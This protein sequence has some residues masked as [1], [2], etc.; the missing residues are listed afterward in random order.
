MKKIRWTLDKEDVREL[1]VASNVLASMDSI[2][3]ANPALTTVEW[4]V[5]S[6]WKD[7]HSDEA[8]KVVEEMFGTL[9]PAASAKGL[10]RFGWEDDL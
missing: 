10:L 8:A 9:L 3:K 4:Q 5:G 2:L 6:A 1:S 7:A